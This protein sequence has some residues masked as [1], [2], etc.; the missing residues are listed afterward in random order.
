M[1]VSKDP[2]ILPILLEVQQQHVRK[3]KTEITIYNRKKKILMACQQ[4]E[5][6]LPVLTKKSTIIE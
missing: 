6:G 5:L 1:E 4:K 3:I 2:W